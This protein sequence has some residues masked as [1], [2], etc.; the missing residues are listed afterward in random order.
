M[1]TPENH[2]GAHEHHPLSQF[3][4]GSFGAR[5]GSAATAAAATA[6]TVPEPDAELMDWLRDMLHVKTSSPYSIRLP[7]VRDVV[8]CSICD[9]RFLAA[10]PTGYHEEAPI[11]DICMLEVEE[12]LGMVL[13][14]VAVI[15]AFASL[16]YDSREE[17]RQA[18]L[19]IGAFAHIYERM[20]MRSG[21][22]RLLVLLRSPWA[23][24]R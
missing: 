4:A 16:Q 6:T 7:A 21:P 24:K 12:E 18:L 20:A 1:M 14:L 13:S 17:K 19:E 11:C 8:T 5:T 23:K 3:L 9:T 2:R 15:R 10:G 22:P